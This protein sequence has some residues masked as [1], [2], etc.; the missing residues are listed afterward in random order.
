MLQTLHDLW[1]GFWSI[2][3]LKLWLTAAWLLYLVPLCAWIVLQKREPV[4]TLSWLLS[5]AMLPYLGYLVYFLLG[6]QKIKRQQLRRS[7]S[8]E[9]L[10]TYEVFAPSDGNSAELPMLAQKITGLPPSTATSVQLLVDGC[11]TYQAL[12]DAI[13]GAQN[14]VHVEYYIFNGDRTGQRVLEALT[15]RA[16]AGVKVRLLLDAVGSGRLK[17]RTLQ[18]LLDAGGEHAWFHPA[19]FRPFTRPWLNL[20][21]HRKIV[22]VDGVVAF[23]G[24]INV[25]D[26]E[27][28][29]LRDDA[30][31]DLHLRM[32]G[33]VVRSVQ[34]VFVEDWVYAT[35]QQRKDF[36]GT[37][38]WSATEANIQGGIA[39]Q[40]LI[41]GPD[42]AWEPIHRLKVAAIHEARKRV[43]LVTP[44]FVPGEAA[45][46]ALT[47]AALGGLDVRL[48]VPKTSDS[49]LVTLAAR[50]Y[51][52]E[53]LAAGVKVYEYGPRMMHSK[54]LLC[55]DG[56]A[57]IGSANFD[58]RSF[59]LNFEI[60]MMFR[61][62][63]VAGTLAQ[64]L[65]GEIAASSQVHPQRDR[66]LW[67]HR[68]PEALA[69]LMSP[70]L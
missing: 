11:A 22:V 28:E 18:P 36:Q 57:I 16:R 51:F 50:S 70:L 12:L 7:R 38:L 9:G 32:E 14:H 41:S 4:A 60:S 42:S 67:R 23:T 33:E 44:Y 56:L 43:W 55:D 47:S 30:Y 64:L 5:L 29:S 35:G 13:A 25:T 45:R 17:R 10:D 61:D 15:E 65:E 68:L 48:V 21:T 6:P 63:G 24:G 54:A 39:T 53:L 66:S 1:T 49:R 59:R 34:Q 58:H 27:D 20:R 37:R 52:D 8:R 26:E 3:N 19:R 31:R 46:M 62:R 2:P 40:T 69:R